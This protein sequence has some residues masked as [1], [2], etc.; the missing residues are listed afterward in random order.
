ML[1][2][3]HEASQLVPEAALVQAA[4]VMIL[5][6]PPVYPEAQVKQLALAVSQSEHPVGHPEVTMAAQEPPSVE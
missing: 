5:A 3:P 2:S 4:P 6:S 1:Q